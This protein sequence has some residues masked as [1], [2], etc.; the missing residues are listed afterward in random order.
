[1]DFLDRMIFQN[2]LLEWLT[3]LGV[4]AGSYI[5]LVL[6]RRITVRNISRVAKRTRTDWDDIVEKLLRQTRRIWLLVIA[7]AIGSRLVELSENGR[8]ALKYV[9]VF[10]TIIQVGVWGRALILALIDRHIAAQKETDPGAATTMAALGIVLQIVMWVVL[11]LMGLQNIG[12]EVAPLLAGLGVGGIAVALAVQNILGDL[13]ASLSIVLDK[14]FVIGDM[15]VVG[16]MSGN[17]EHIGLKTTRVRSL[18]GEQLVF[19][20]SDM[21][22]ARIRNFKRMSERRILFRVGVVYQTPRD[23]VEA[24][25]GMLREAVEAQ[26]LARFD[27]A[28]FT[29]FGPSSLDFEVVYFVKS[30]EYVSYMNTQ[31]AIN[32]MVLDRFRS[33]GIEFAYPTQTL[34][35]ETIGGGNREKK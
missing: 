15:V 25:P 7:L 14:P 24:I 22:S 13:F 23:L 33:A 16:E 28:H 18:S 34:F 17:V 2:T 19:S 6:L 29:S 31:Q 3:A 21:L 12:I 11:V 1:M 20:N 32:L 4:A 8:L 27:R 5:A 26:E 35:V 10:V 30:P 9:V